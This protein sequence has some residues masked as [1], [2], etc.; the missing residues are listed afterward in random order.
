LSGH[1][2][3]KRLSRRCK[4]RS[5]I[6]QSYTSLAEKAESGVITD[7]SDYG[8]VLISFRKFLVDGLIEE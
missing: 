4:S 1:L 8:K 6:A 5:E 2:K 3:L 7:A